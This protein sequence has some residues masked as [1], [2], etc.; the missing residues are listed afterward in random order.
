[1]PLIVIVK[2]AG[3]HRVEDPTLDEIAD[4]EAALK[5]QPACSI[6]VVAALILQL[7]SQPEAAV[8]NVSGLC[9]RFRIKSGLAKLGLG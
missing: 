4:A 7:V 6:R 5:C 3:I 1:M 2:N 9:Y 8:L